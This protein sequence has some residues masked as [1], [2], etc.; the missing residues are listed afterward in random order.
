MPIT[1][2][3]RNRIILTPEDKKFIQENWNSKTNSE[4]ADALGLKLT[5]LRGFLREMGLKRMELEYWNEEQVQWLKWNYQYYG[6]V[7]IAEIFNQLYLKKKSWTLKHIEKKRMYL[8]LNR[9]KSELEQIQIRNTI[10]GRFAIC[11]KKR[12][13]KTGRMPFGSIFYWN[14]G[15]NNKPVLYIKTKDGYHMYYRYLWVK[16]KGSLNSDQL[17]VA[18]LD[19]PSNSLLDVSQLEVIS[20]TEH[21]IRNNKARM[22][23]PEDIRQVIK[24]YNKLKKQLKIKEDGQQSTNA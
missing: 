2:G 10:N 15:Y 9:S 3:N 21:A 12:W 19:A 11:V 20:R 23:Y 5:K 17:V 18:K 16:Q 24:T 8:K 1:V 6:D 7:E 13:D 14:T 22:E 4:L